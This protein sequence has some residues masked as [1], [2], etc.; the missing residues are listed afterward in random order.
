MTTGF[1]WW[2]RSKTGYF[3]V[4]KVDDELLQRAREY[5]ERPEAQKMMTDMITFHSEVMNE[6]DPILQAVIEILNKVPDSIK[7][8]VSQSCAIKFLAMTLL[9]FEQG[10]AKS[11]PDSL[12]STEYIIDMLVT[13]TVKKARDEFSRIRKEHLANG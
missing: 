3:L 9:I 7:G 12:P 5:A 8:T 11:H 6:I 2:Q 10:I 4:E 1:I 13:N